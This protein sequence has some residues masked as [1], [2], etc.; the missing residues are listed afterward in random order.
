MSRRPKPA[1][2]HL[3]FARYTV[4]DEFLA[5]PTSPAP[6]G[7]FD[8]RIKAARA[9][10]VELQNPETAKL[11]PWAVVCM[12]ANVVETM[13]ERGVA[14]DPDGLLRDAFEALRRAV[15]PRPGTEPAIE[16]SAE[17]LE[18]VSDMLDGWVALITSVNH[19]RVIQCFRAT[20]RRVLEI[21]AGRGRAGDV[22]V[23]GGS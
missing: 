5:S 20:D 9:A 7:L 16:L 12:A 14:A 23:E 1:A 18:C 15:T 21:E 17:A 13:L 10:L 11:A 3:S 6:R 4:M 19:R 2:K 8:A 22:R